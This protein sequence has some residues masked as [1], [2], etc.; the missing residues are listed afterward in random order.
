MKLPFAKVSESEFHEN[1]FHT[2]SQRE[3][4]DVRT[5]YFPQKSVFPTALSTSRTSAI[6]LS[7]SRLFLGN[8]ASTYIYNAQ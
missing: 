3:I 1:F 2:Y 8:I 7:S 5:P 4:R 6:L